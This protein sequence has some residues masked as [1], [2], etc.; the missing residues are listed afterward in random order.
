[1]AHVYD[2]QSR[3]SGWIYMKNL[4]G[5][6]IFIDGSFPKNTKVKIIERDVADEYGYEM[7][8]VE[9]QNEPKT[10]GWTYFHNLLADDTCAIC[11]ESITT[12]Q[13]FTSRCGHQ[14]HLICKADMVAH[15]Q[16]SCPLCR[17]AF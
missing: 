15:G 2:F 1:M 17:K 3:A 13:L 9:I 5:E 11:L 14:F 16:I 6:S 12:P 10:T 4:K 8:K 7:V